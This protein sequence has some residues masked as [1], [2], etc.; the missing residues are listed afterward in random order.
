VNQIPHFIKTTHHDIELQKRLNWFL[1]QPGCNWTLARSEK[2]I[3]PELT[4]SRQGVSLNYGTNRLAFHPSMALI[5]LI[6]LLRGESDRFLEATQLKPGDF[7]I[8]ATLGL[9]T[10]ALVG[11]WAVGE[12]GKVLA[13]EKSPILAALVKDGLN[14]FSEII[15]PSPKRDKLEAWAKLAQAARR[16]EISRGEHIEYFNQFPSCSVDVVYFDP[17]FRQTYERSHSIQPLH[18]WSDHAPLSPAAVREACRIARQRVVL[19]ERKDSSEF[20]R[21]GFAVI[22][23]G[24]YSSVDYGVIL[25]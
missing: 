25:V 22:E 9:G 14:H 12:K 23:G 24:R 3:L 8:D 5:R 13:V 11:A 7:L 1:Q 21:L 10:D 6:N 17:M 2:E 15:E 18:F 16:I 4:I 20:R 19:K